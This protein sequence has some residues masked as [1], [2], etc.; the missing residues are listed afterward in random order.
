MEKDLE[1]EVSNFKVT[2]DKMYK[3][4]DQQEAI[5]FVLFFTIA[6]I[7]LI[8]Y[9]NYYKSKKNMILIKC[10]VTDKTYRTGY[11]KNTYIYYYEYQYKDETYTDSDSTRFK[12]LFNPNIKDELNI[13]I[14]PKKPEKNITPYIILLNK[15]YLIISILLIILPFLLII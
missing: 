14:N 10:L 3:A 6:V 4:M 2:L 7:I 15:I 9:Y 11:E 8:K 1:I 13:Y 5:M 12:V